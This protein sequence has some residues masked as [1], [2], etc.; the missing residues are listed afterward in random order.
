MRVKSNCYGIPIQKYYFTQPQHPNWHD[1]LLPTAYMDCYSPAKPRLFNTEYRHTLLTDLTPDETSIFQNFPKDT[2]NQIRRCE[3]EQRFTLNLNTPLEQFMPLYNA[4]AQTRGLSLFTEADA[5]SIG[6]NNYAI[7]SAD[8][9]GSP[10]I[11]HF[12][13][14]SAATSCTNLLISASSQ[15]YKHDPDMRRAMGFANRCLHWQGMC[16]FKKAGF[17]T[18]D[19]GGY[20][21][22]TNDPIMQGINR[23]KRTFNGKKVPLYNYYS[24]AYGFIELA[25]QKL[26]ELRA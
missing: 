6:R 25:R 21:E 4:F 18:Y 10:V 22:N 11:C 12:Y 26:R 23:F 7:F 1:L 16:H 5:N 8:Y 2:R 13:L 17:R 3:Q 9:A 20:V 19:W 15:A 24:P 14:I